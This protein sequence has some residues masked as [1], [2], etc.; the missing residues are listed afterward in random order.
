MGCSISG[1]IGSKW[2]CGVER[3]LSAWGGAGLRG[4]REEFESACSWQARTVKSWFTLLNEG[5]FEKYK[6]ESAG[7]EDTA[8][9]MK[10]GDFVGARTRQRP[11]TQTQEK[12]K[13]VWVRGAVRRGTQTRT[14]AVVV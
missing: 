2:L 5:T 6:K 13:L 1:R 7:S 10:G 14:L 8:S 9:M 11:T 4:E 12:K 3:A